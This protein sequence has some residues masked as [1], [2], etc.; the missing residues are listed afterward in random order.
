MEQ[1]E[2]FVT[3]IEFEKGINAMKDA[4]QELSRVISQD[5]INLE[6]RFKE[7]TELHHDNALCI[8]KNNGQIE[9]LMTMLVSQS[10]FCRVRREQTDKDKYEIL[11]KID[12][13]RDTNKEADDKIHALYEFKSEMKGSTQASKRAESWVK[14]GIGIIISIASIAIALLSIMKVKG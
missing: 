12:E 2:Q 11:H 3:R 7:I 5:R 13:V 8:Q 14:W 6:K 4:I 1:K 10:E 9:K